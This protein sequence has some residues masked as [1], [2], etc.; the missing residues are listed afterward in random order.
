[1]ANYAAWGPD[2]LLYVTDFQQ[3]VAVA[4]AAGRRRGRGSG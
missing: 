3:G 1:M 2:G 4:G